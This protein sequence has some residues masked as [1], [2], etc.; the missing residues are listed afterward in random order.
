MKAPSEA[1]EQMALLEWFEWTHPN[2]L[3]FHIPNGERRDAR[4][5][6]KLKKLGVK[7]GIPDLFIPAWGVWIEMKSA[8]GR[9]TLEQI[10]MYE[11]LERVGY[12]VLACY[13]FEDAKTKLTALHALKARISEGLQD[14]ACNCHPGREGNY[15]AFPAPPKDEKAQDST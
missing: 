13:G 15:K 4:T 2:I 3:I 5:G 7:R 14:L 12:D 10:D 11:Y 9:L 8:K 1:Q 6:H